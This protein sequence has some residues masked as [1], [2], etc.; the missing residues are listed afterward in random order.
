MNYIYELSNEETDNIEK[1]S[2]N[3][4]EIKEFILENDILGNIK[5]YEKDSYNKYYS[6]VDDYA[7]LP[8]IQDS[9]RAWKHP[10][11]NVIMEG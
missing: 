4:D 5:L 6:S 8:E 11:C 1:I 3:Y 2:E 9:W 10:E 7:D